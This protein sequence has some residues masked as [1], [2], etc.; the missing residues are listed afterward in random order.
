MDV[1]K[2]QKR[3][4]DEP[5]QED[6]PTMELYQKQRQEDYTTPVA[7]GVGSVLFFLFC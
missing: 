5:T 7:S 4:K 2:V 1:K 6:Y 3:G